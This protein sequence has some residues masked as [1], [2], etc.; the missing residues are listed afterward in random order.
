SSN[1]KLS[2]LVTYFETRTPPILKV[3]SEFSGICAGSPV[4]DIGIV[5]SSYKSCW[6]HNRAKKTP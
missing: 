5:F 2:Y 4:L 1:D 3:T 6:I